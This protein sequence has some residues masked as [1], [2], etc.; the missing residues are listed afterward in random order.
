MAGLTSAEID[1]TALAALD[2]LGYTVARQMPAR[3]AIE[4]LM[5]GYN[6]DCGEQDWKL[7]FSVRG[8]T[9]VATIATTEL[10]AR[11]PD[12]RDVD[13][14][15]ESIQQDIE[16]PT[17]LTLNYM[18]KTRDYDRA[19]QHS[20]RADKSMQV[21]M[22]IDVPLVFSDTQA[23]QL[24]ETAHKILY[25]ARRKYRFTTTMKYLLLSPTD[26]ATVGGKLMRVTAVNYRLPILEF[27]AESE[28]GG[29]YTG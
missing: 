19:S 2:V 5:V 12:D 21:P 7:K 27:S 23:K 11:S 25:Q 20:Y 10:A 3:S 22:T 8:G 13:R 24:V 16:I 14:M 15:I 4:P 6:V 26:L 28:E 9:S 18:S 1:V 17:H 29:A